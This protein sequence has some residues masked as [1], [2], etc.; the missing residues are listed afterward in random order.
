MVICYKCTPQELAVLLPAF[1]KIA[2]A[3]DAVESPPTVGFK[4]S[5]LNNIIYALPKL[6]EPMAKLIEAVSLKKAAEGRK[7]TM[8]TDP[9]QY[10]KIADADM[11]SFNR[12]MSNLSL[13]LC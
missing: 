3:F 11:V 6:R 5:V 12:F 10:P 9:E 2:T 1:N 8:W 13:P 7:D 4:S